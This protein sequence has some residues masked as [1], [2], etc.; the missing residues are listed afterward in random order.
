MVCPLKLQKKLR[1]ACRGPSFWLVSGPAQRLLGAF[2]LT[3]LA[4]CWAASPLQLVAGASPLL[5]LVA[6][7][8]HCSSTNAMFPATHKIRRQSPRRNRQRTVL[9][10][11]ASHSAAACSAAQSNVPAY[12]LRGLAPSLTGCARTDKTESRGPCCSVTVHESVTPVQ[13]GRPGPSKSACGQPAHSCT[14]CCLV[15]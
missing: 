4:R 2:L 8:S 7:Q 6:G 15:S 9:S 12:T 11:N 14:H 13:K 5:R 10:L 1:T 3:A